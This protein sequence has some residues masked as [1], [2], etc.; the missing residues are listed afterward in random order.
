VI[1]RLSGFASRSPKLLL[2]IVA[3]AFV[4]LGA[5]GAPVAERLTAGGF[6]SPDDESSRAAQVLSDDFGVSG[7]QLILAV[8][9]GDATASATA[10][11]ASEIVGQLRADPDIAAAVSPWTDPQYR[12]KLV[13]D[14]K[15]E[16][17]IVAL[18]RGGDDA[19]P[20]KASEIASHYTGERDGVTIRAGGQAIVFHEANTQAAHDLMLAEAIALPL[21]FLLLVWFLRSAIAAAIPIATGMVAIVGTTAIL[22]L[23]TF[24]VELSIFAMNLTAAIGLAL[25]ID[26]SLLIISR[27][28][29]EIAAGHSNEKA[30]ALSMRHAGR[31]VCYSGVTVAIGVVGMVFFPM[32]FL[33]SIAFAGVAVVLLSIILSLTM[34]PALLTLFGD[35][36]N[37]KPLREAAPVEQ[38]PLYRVARRVQ[39]NPIAF[40]LP[41]VVLLIALGAPA[42]GLKLGLPDERVLPKPSAAQQVGADIRAKFSDNPTGV[43]HIVVAPRGAADSAAL[44]RYTDELSRVDGVSGVI[45]PAGTF[46]DGKQVGPGVATMAGE[47]NAYLTVSTTSD[48]YSKR[49]RVQLDEIRAVDAPAPILIGGLAQQTR[50][51][52][53]GIT[54]AFPK[55][56]AWIIVVTFV[57][58]LLLTGSVVLP[59]KALILNTLSLSAT[60]GALVWIFQDGNLGGFGT[61]PSGYIAAT[62]PALVFCVA[63]GLSMDYEVFLLSRFREEWDA[64]GKTRAD[65]D[66]A[67]AIGLSRSGRVITAAAALMVVVFAAVITSQLSLMRAFGL[68]LTLAVLIDA[69]LVRFILVPAFMRLFGTW[70]WWAPSWMRPFLAKA[71]L[72]ESA[73]PTTTTPP[74]REMA[75]VH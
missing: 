3:A 51:T 70:N 52:A 38:S 50:D 40:G 17:L 34:V 19:A 43:V 37:R 26:Y 8:E 68:G 25:A 11:R 41:V 54:S 39:R 65:N 67:V 58:L 46:V 10:G 32:S 2:T 14:D 7:M 42:L 73:P 9:S 56:L 64:S 21:C 48:P 60:F 47:N 13:S 35:R 30:I 1:D 59:L 4:I 69:T 62:V 72:R 15:T 16:G 75:N 36:I 61:V 22:F 12:A 24:V 6:T 63:F 49:A 23:L 18:V 53:T 45:G 28:R 57:L 31:A 5:V 55:A 71:A 33:R 29:E 66:T 20:A 27:Y 44:A 74:G